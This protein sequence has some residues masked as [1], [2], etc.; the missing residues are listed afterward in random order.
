[1][2][3]GPAETV[4]ELCV[5]YHAVQQ[6]RCVGHEDLLG[7]TPTGGLLL[8]GDTITVELILTVLPGADASN[9][10]NYSEISG[11]INDNGDEVADEHADST[12][13]Q[14]PGNDAGGNPDG[15]SDNTFGGDGS[16][17]PLDDDGTTD[18]D[19]HDPA[20]VDI[21][22]LALTKIFLI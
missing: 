19:D 14:D 16:G 4:P 2:D 7:E 11:A 20:I 5:V 18:E 17:S 12:P 1:M 8:T 9:T 6:D 10:V 3:C 13:E 21:Y 22:D 15:M